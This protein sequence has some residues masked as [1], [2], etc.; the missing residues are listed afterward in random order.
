MNRFFVY[1]P[2]FAWVVAL[3]A[4]LFG[5]IALRNLPVET[6]PNIAPPSVNV[7]ATFPGAD[8]ATLDRTVTSIIEREMNGVDNF[9]YMS[10]VSRANGTAQIT[11][12]F[13]PGTDLEVARSQVQDRLGRAEP[14]LP[15]EVRQLG[16]RVT[17]SSAGFLMVIALKSKTGSSS[18]LDM[19]NFASN[20]L[21]DELRR[22]RGVG[23]VLLFGSPYAMRIWLDRDRLAGFGLSPAE[24]LAA[25]REQNSQ[26]AGGSLGAQPIAPGS[27]F[28][29]QIITQSRFSSAQQFRDIIVASRPD[30][31]TV[32]LGD[33]ARVELGQDS[34]GFRGTLNGAE[35]AVL[36]VQLATGASALSTAQ[37]VV[38]RMKELQSGF[39]PDI[40]WTIPF[41]TT[42]FITA[43]VRN[44]LETMVETMVLVSIVVFLFLQRWRTTV[45]PTLIVPIALLGACLGLFLFGLSI[46]LLSLFAMVVAIGILNDDAIVIVENV[47]R[48]MRDEGLSPREATVKAMGQITVAIVATTLVLMAVFAPMAFFPGSSGGIYRQFSITLTVAIVVS[49]ILSLTLAPA[50]C[51]SLL[52]APSAADAT[53]RPNLL[54]RFFGGFNTFM[55][56][57]TARY[58]R[59]VDAMLAAPLLW[60]GGFA[61]FCV[62][63]VLLFMRLPGGFLPNED[64]GYFF[65][66]YNAAP[67][68]SMQ[69]TEAAVAQA[70]AFLRKQPQ[71]RNVVTVV[72]FSFFG[73]GQ[74]VAMS[75]VDLYPWAKRLGR[76]DSASALVQRANRAFFTIPQATVFA[77]EPPPIQSLGNATGFSMMVQDRAGEGSGLVQA[78]Q[79]MLVQAAKS[80][81]LAGVR[82]ES[83]P[84]TP[85]LYVE[86]DRIKARALGLQIGQVNQA[87]SIVFGSAYANDFVHEGNVLRVFVQ[88][89]A[90]QRMRAEDVASLRTRND[91]GEMVPFSA[92]TTMHWTAGPQQLER[93]NGFPSVTL[94]GQAAPGRSSGDALHEMERIA[95]QVLP[96]GYGFEWT[97]TA[98]EERQAGGQIGALL[99]LSVIVTF[100]LLAALYESW[101]LPLAILMV[102]PLGVIG[103]VVLTMVRGMSADIY[104]NVGLVT[105]IGLAAKNAILIVQFAI[106]EEAQ[107]TPTLVATRQA[108]EQRLRPILMTSLTF[109]IGMLPLVFASG[110][111]AASRQAV[112]TG[113]MGSMLSAT[114]FGIFFTPLFFVAARRWLGGMRGEGG[115]EAPQPVGGGPVGEAEGG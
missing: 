91:R 44:V 21:V 87:L 99:G 36:G 95:H 70:E 53:R 78:G 62:V 80:P 3:F 113:V 22:V 40:T 12:T 72:G 81:N 103:A 84:P 55:E 74:S 105:I 8:A 106:D 110:A 60:L 32:R 46:N 111:G 54:G 61:A 49:T 76:D 101:A 67:G 47:E 16:V 97:G 35:T 51:G 71:V 63:V 17:A 31:S 42:P 93:Y 112:G 104:F 59:G 52:R 75:F 48:I 82:L 90:S 50:L 69:R 66:A 10:A 24:V 89:D 4:L 27:E 115:L 83:L 64:Q 107:G 6:Y 77:L 68:A 25:I 45:V 13:R 57:S 58:L 20:N 2:V 18:A 92:F 39:P 14:R 96:T 108:A 43:S 26:T 28:N 33:V 100:L 88:G 65:V 9:L 86:V 98:F 5:G 23:D 109:V 34:Y 11:V 19:D 102:V 85:Q 114:F 7:A 1:H 37:A 30:G 41:D 73:Q 79:A 29:A 38:A 94:S 15:Q 56:R